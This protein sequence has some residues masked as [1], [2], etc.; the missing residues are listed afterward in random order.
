MKYDEIIEKVKDG[1]KFFINLEK[2]TLR[3][4]GK[5]ISSM[6]VVSCHIRHHV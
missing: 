3:L 2:R 1:A 4:D 6:D 5:L